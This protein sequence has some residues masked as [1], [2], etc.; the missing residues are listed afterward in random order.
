[1]QDGYREAHPR[2]LI[3]HHETSVVASHAFHSI[4]LL[5]LKDDIFFLLPRLVIIILSIRIDR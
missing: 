3:C 5:F 4:F 2:L 1:M